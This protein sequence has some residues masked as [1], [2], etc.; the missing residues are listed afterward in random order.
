MSS[1]AG[2]GTD[3]IEAALD[4]LLRG[5]AGA[6]RRICAMPWVAR[7]NHRA[8]RRSAYTGDA[9]ELTI[10]RSLQEICERALDDAVGRMRATG[11]DIVVLDPQDGSILALASRR[12][13]VGE[14]AAT[15]LTEPFEP[16]STLKPFIAAALLARGRVSPTDMVDTHAGHL[17]HERTD[18]DRHALTRRP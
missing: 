8:P 10:N 12:P 1:S 13:G 11:G 9:V 7:W 17:V 2:I 16:G 5:D 15:T 6:R 3:G 4:S 14:A 18:V